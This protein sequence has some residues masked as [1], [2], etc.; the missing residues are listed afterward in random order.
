MKS[1]GISYKRR[2]LETKNT[3]IYFILFTVIL[4]WI[5]ELKYNVR[6]MKYY[7]IDRVKKKR[8]IENC[9]ETS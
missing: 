8:E 2:L 4:K 6:D 3:K 7:K 1:V 9:D 5:F